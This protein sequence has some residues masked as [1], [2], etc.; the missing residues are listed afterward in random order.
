MIQIYRPGDLFNTP[1]RPDRPAKRG[2]FNVSR[3]T[4][5][6]EIEPHLE[7]VELGPKAVGYTDRSVEREQERRI[8]KAAD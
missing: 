6:D 8:V 4:F 2:V 1:A 3:S 5:Y 7:R